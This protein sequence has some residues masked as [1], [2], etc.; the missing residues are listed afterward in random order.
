MSNKLFV[1]GTLKDGYPN[2]SRLAGA[3]FLGRA[4][5][6]EKYTMVYMGFPGIVRNP[7]HLHHVGEVYEVS[8]KT[9]AKCDALEGHPTWYIRE[10]VDV[11]IFDGDPRGI[12]KA[13]LYFYPARL[14]L[15]NN[16]ISGWPPQT[17][18]ELYSKHIK[19]TS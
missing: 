2:H 11:D 3:K 18:G 17:V 4:R 12:V 19:T 15:S 14:A 8:D 6:V 9:L 1:Y 7:P 10:L 16:V 13:W 5:T